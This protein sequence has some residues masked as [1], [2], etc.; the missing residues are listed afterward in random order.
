[1]NRRRTLI[2]RVTRTWLVVLAV[3][4]LLA[5]QSGAVF[6]D[7]AS[8]TSNTFS[9]APSF[10]FI[11]TH[12]VTGAGT[13]NAWSNPANVAVDDDVTASHLLARRSPT[14]Y[15]WAVPAFDE[16]PAGATISSVTI[17]MRLYNT[18]AN[19]TTTFGRA[20]TNGTTVVGSAGAPVATDDTTEAVVT[21][22]AGTVTLAQLKNSVLQIRTIEDKDRSNPATLHIDHMYVTVVY[23][24]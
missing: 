7:A 12:S 23:T 22:N 4:G 13:A 9:T 18:A 16:I 5:S 14:T 10:P 21:H 24:V 15:Y 2:L 8:N 20:L 11:V 3:A 6:T 1:M 19:T 17:G